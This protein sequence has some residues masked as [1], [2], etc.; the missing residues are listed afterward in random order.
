[1]RFHKDAPRHTLD[2]SNGTGCL[3]ISYTW[4]HFKQCCLSNRWFM[5]VFVICAH[6]W[7]CIGTR[8]V[9]V[10]S[11]KYREALFLIF[12]NWSFKSTV[13]CPRGSPIAL[14]WFICLNVEIKKFPRAL[15]LD[16]VFRARLGCLLQ[17]HFIKI[18]SLLRIIP[19]PVIIDA[20]KN[21]I[22]II[23]KILN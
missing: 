9:L 16:P 18:A 4:V 14:K 7:C 22:F 15:P 19:S 6:C 20:F 13:P 10:V 3:P 21:E 8:K 23:F 12:V 2:C 17:N 11:T 5:F 1:M